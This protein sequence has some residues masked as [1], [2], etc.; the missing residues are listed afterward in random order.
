MKNICLLSCFLLFGLHINAQ[1]FEAGVETTYGRT[2]SSFKGDLAGMVGFSEIEITEEQ[3]DTAFARF[4]LDAPRWLRELFPGIRIEVLGEVSKKLNRNTKS[5]RFFA[6]YQFIGGSFIISDPRL[7]DPLESKKLKNQIKALRLSMG[8]KTE[9]LAEHLAIIALEDETKVKPFFNNRYDAELYL[10]LKKLFLPDY[11]LAEWGKQNNSYLDFEVTSGLRF[12]ADPSPVLDLGSILFVQEKLD[13]LME[14][15]LL[16]PVENITDQ[17]AEGIQNVVF[18]K[19]KD[20][21]VVPSWGWFVR[22][23]LVANFGSGLSLVTGA[24]MSV[25]KH[26]S[27]KGTKAMPSIYAFAGFRV[28]VLGKGRR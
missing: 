19:F 23:E 22:P 14:G 18:G 4:D 16:G 3:I 10:H 9:E 1:H 21:R 12:T 28:N 24:E 7:T 13:S 20:P 26:T 17:I 2:F 5:I 25:N 27:I 6:R 8:G 15:G 11:V